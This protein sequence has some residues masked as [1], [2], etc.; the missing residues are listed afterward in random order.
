VKINSLQDLYVDQLRDLYDAEN[1]L[2]KTLPKLA[3]E[4]SSDELREGF[5]EHLEQTRGHVQRLEQIFERLGEKPKGK[6]C[7]AMEG[8]N[9]RRRYAG[10]H[11]GR[12]HNRC[13]PTCRAL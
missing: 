7:K 9:P 6:K 11:K 4:S 8:L 10:R 2:V 5:E 3:E 13:R 1:Q 12:W